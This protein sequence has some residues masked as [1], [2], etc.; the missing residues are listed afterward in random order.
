MRQGSAPREALSANVKMVVGLMRFGTGA[1]VR[2][3]RVQGGVG[4]GIALR[5]A[6]AQRPNR[7][8]TRTTGGA[9]ARR[10]EALRVDR[11]LGRAG[12]G[13]AL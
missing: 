10:T 8:P 4:S 1:A 11:Y 2:R 12:A 13:A 5:E 3:S 7:R 6:L 9:T